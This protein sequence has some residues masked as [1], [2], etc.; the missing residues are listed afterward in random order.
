MRADDRPDAGWG[1]ATR[2][3]HTPPGRYPAQQPLGL[4][5]FRTAAFA[6]DST[7][8]YAELLAGERAGYAY[9]RVS[10]PTTDAFATA[11]AALETPA[12]SADAANIVGEPCASG[13]AAVASTL[14][15]LC[16]PGRH[17]IAPREIYGGTYGILT[18]M[19]A[20]FGVRTDFVPM[21]DLSAVRAALRP[22]TCL[23]WAETLANPTMAVADLPGLAAL[24]H[25]AGV[26]LAVDSTFASPAMCRPLEHGADLVVHSATKYIGGHSDVTGGVVVGRRSRVAGVHAARVQLGGSL[27]PDDA[28]LLHRGLATL[29]LRVARQC[30]SAGQ[31]A[32]AL[33]ADPRVRRVHYPGLP[34]HPDH[35]LAGR[36]LDPGRFGA[37]LSIVVPGGR[38]GAA[39]VS[40]AARLAVLATSLGG[41][42]TKLSPVAVTTHSQL[43]DAALAAADI[44][45]GTIRISVGLEDSHDL[46]VDLDRA[47]GAVGT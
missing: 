36:V 23:I 4:P 34:D 37:V 17:V 28:F 47:L 22:E 19:L 10:N 1:E 29:P 2:A 13:M 20:R 16:G 35:E 24:A 38:A 21:R 32:G 3:V 44:D 41:T 18:S 11:V 39:A 9:S 25:D 43:D 14:F 31:L 30:A 40:D 42:H 5:V 26:P 46:L 33:A 27:S 15:A 12:G 7:A 6:F 8:E 45:P